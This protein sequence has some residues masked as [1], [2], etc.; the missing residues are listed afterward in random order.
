MI[1]TEEYERMLD[2]GQ[3]LSAELDERIE[4]NPDDEELKETQEFLADRH[5]SL[6]FLLDA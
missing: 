2:A 4:E 1:S 6:L 3:Q 5:W